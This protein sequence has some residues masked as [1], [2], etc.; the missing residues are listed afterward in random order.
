DTKIS[1]YIYSDW[2]LGSNISSLTFHN[3][4]THTSGFGQLASN[5]CG[6]D[7]T[8]SAL[9]TIVANGVSAANIGVPTNGN[10]NFGRLRELM[11]VLLKPSPRNA[12]DGPQRA[13]QSSAMYIGYM[14]SHVFQPV[15]VKDSSC[16]PPTDTSGIL[17]YPYPAG[18]T[19][20]IDWGDWSLQCG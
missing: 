10:C 6:N 14:Q 9:K 13:K 3:L 7:V 18:A 20:G 1:S 5:A 16:K 4:L 11:P 12:P 15:G 8:Y 19:S 17:S 2:K